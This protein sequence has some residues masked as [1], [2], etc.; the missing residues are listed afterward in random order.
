MGLSI[1]GLILFSCL[2]CNADDVLDLSNNQ[3]KENEALFAINYKET[4]ESN[5]CP[6][7]GPQRYCHTLVERGNFNLNGKFTIVQG[8]KDV[9]Q[10]GIEQQNVEQQEEVVQFNF[11]DTNGTVFGIINPDKVRADW[12][13]NF[14]QLIYGKRFDKTY[15]FEDPTKVHKVEPV[16][17]VV[18]VGCD[19][20][21]LDQC[22]F[23]AGEKIEEDLV[24]RIEQKSNVDYLT[25]QVI[26]EG[27]KYKTLYVIDSD[28]VSTLTSAVG[29]YV[30]CEASIEISTSSVKNAAGEPILTLPA[31][32]ACDAEVKNLVLDSI[33]QC[34]Q[35]GT[36]QSV[37]T[38]EFNGSN[39][40]SEFGELS[41][42]TIGIEVRAVLTLDSGGTYYVLPIND[43][44]LFQYHN[45]KVKVIGTTQVYDVVQKSGE[46][47][48]VSEVSAIEVSL[49]EQKNNL[50][51]Y[52]LKHETRFDVDMLIY[53]RVLNNR[54]YFITFDYLS[55]HYYTPISLGTFDPSK[56]NWFTEYKN[57]LNGLI[58]GKTLDV[59]GVNLGRMQAGTTSSLNTSIYGI[60]PLFV[61][62]IEGNSVSKIFPTA[63]C[64]NLPCFKFSENETAAVRWVSYSGIIYKQ[65]FEGSDTQTAQNRQLIEDNA[66]AYLKYQMT[67]QSRADFPYISLDY[68]EKTIKVLLLDDGRI[69]FNPDNNNIAYY[70]ESPLFTF[71]EQNKNSHVIFVLAGG[72][73]TSS[74]TFNLEGFG[75]TAFGYVAHK[76]EVDLNSRVKCDQIPSDILCKDNI[77][78]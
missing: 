50:I 34:E 70:K 43:M 24:L 63:N 57:T 73:N 65:T 15:F 12:L 20:D 9:E 60:L 40:F 64:V 6:E 55:G 68:P 35:R 7:E 37:S 77:S 44:N 29:K 32:S 46:S 36:C 76:Y 54:E 33:S 16:F 31:L 22:E 49:K 71:N 8:E 11:I 56:D 2:S 42:V 23:I 74:Q 58:S 67:Q 5:V 66:N 78:D 1:G 3:G 48:I 26:K 69:G 72:E 45:R 13:G 14:D 4:M 59:L 51:N 30:S 21:H 41:F 27:F 47:L 25:A 18:G 39:A 75:E 10:Q 61:Q 28:L 62:T 17:E 38:K 19:I 52:E 53:D